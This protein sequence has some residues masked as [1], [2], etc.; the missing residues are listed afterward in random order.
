MTAASADARARIVAAAVHEAADRIAETTRFVHDHPEAA[1]EET[2]SAAHLAAAL[3]EAGL[4][5]ESGVGGLPTAFKAVLGSDRP[6]PT[7]ALIAVYDAVVVP[8]PDGGTAIHH[9][10]GH[11]P[12]SGAVVGAALALQALPDRAGTVVVI[13]APADELVSP[14]AIGR[15]SGKAVL[16]ERGVLDGIDAA[17][18]VHPESHTGVWR[19]SRWMRLIEVVA[20][21]GADPAAWALPEGQVRVG[22]VSVLETGEVA[23]VLR[24]LG[25]DRAELDERELLARTLVDALRWTPLGTTEGLQADDTVAAAA[26][27]ALGLL[28]VPFGRELPRMPF[29]TDFGNVSRRIRSA[30]VGLAHPSQPEGWAVHLEEGERQFRSEAGEVV[31][32]QAAAVLA[33]AADLLTRAEAP[34]RSPVETP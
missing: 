27:E 10:C 14:L 6:G 22:D 12:V 30:M 28:G 13:G 31:A 24:V 4:D 32:G 8:T 3:R 21:A 11:G 9:S 19:S 7:V 17:L 18:Y 1:H 23:A 25:D 29:S 20:P 2:A 5:V 16:L 15:G 26:E 33:L 34:G